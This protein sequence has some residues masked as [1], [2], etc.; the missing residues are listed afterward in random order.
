MVLRGERAQRKKK[1][2]KQQVC[3]WGEG[4][5]GHHLKKLPKGGTSQESHEKSP[6]VDRG[7]KG[8]DRLASYKMG[9]RSCYEPTI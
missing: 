4:M 5:K 7:E 6:Y 3:V 8:W 2:R 9:K 1:N